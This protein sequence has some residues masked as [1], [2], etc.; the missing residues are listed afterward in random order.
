MGYESRLFVV[1]KNG[2]CFDDEYEWAENIAMF[3]MCC[4]GGVLLSRICENPVTNCHFSNGFGGTVSKDGY[5]TPLREIPLHKMV[6]ILEEVTADS[7]YR[8]FAPLLAMLKVFDADNKSK[9]NNELVVLHY[10]Y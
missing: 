3:N 9:W 7:D 4:I 6:E 5:G 10:G 8:R 1:R 2:R